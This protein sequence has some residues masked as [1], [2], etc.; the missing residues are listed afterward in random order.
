VTLASW[1]NLQQQNVIAYIQ[2]E[3][4]ILKN[5]LK[6]KRIRFSDDEEIGATDGPV[7]CRERLGRLLLSGDSDRETA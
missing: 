6:G 1:I 5:K 4:R 3:N 7:A 2:A